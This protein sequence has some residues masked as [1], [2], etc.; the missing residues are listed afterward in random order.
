[1]IETW[2]QIPDFPDYEVSDHGQVYSKRRDLMLSLTQ[3]SAGAVKVNLMAN[4]RL[5]TRA[6]KTLVAEAFLP[7]H[8]PE[9]NTPINLDGDPLNNHVMNLA[10]RPRWFAWKYTRQ[11]HQE[12]PVFY[13]ATVQNLHSGKIYDSTMA[14]GIDDGII[15]EY[16]WN[17]VISGRPVY[18]T[19]AVYH[20]A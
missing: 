20:L 10:W 11:F 4:G 15:W 5:C 14:A 6:V 12:I 16:L 19:G 3:T 17:S 2:A 9:S 1:M 13:N 8:H 7:D 18:P